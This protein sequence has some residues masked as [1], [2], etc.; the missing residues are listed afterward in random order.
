AE[1][2]LKNNLVKKEVPKEKEVDLSVIDDINYYTEYIS[3]NVELYR[4]IFNL[5]EERLRE[6][7]KEVLIEVG[8]KIISKSVTIEDINQSI[9]KRLK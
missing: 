8:I 2:I 3:K 7:K 4:S 1:F 6:I 5:S 9:I